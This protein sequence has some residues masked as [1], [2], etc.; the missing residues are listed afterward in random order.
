LAITKYTLIIEVNETITEMKPI[1]TDENRQQKSLGFGMRLKMAR[2][3]L[4]L[5]QKEAAAHL[6]LSP[7]IIQIL[8]TEDFRNAPP[9]TFM[10]GYLRSYGR[11][12]NLSE[13][14][15]NVALLES[16]LNLKPDAPITPLLNIATFEKTDSYTR[17]TTPFIV[18]ILIVLVGMWWNSHGRYSTS[19]LAPLLT[20]QVMHPASATE[21]ITTP[22]ITT[23]S[24]APSFQPENT[25]TANAPVAP[26]T[27]TPSIDTALPPTTAASPGTT[28]VPPSATPAPGSNTSTTE[29]PAASPSTEGV[30][31]P[32]KN[33]PPQNKTPKNRNS[34]IIMALP[35]PGL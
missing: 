11:L 18:L 25:A 10:R 13:E 30:D 29:M 1:M 33:P 8:E 15:V 26:Q 27:I 5:S 31:A 22:P 24:P 17:W 2:E 34:N 20:Q 14:E 12:L 19:S 21:P 16:N 4:N 32:R 35:E 3:S 28:T 23:E 7:T 9:A 6:H